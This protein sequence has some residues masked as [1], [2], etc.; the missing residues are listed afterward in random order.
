MH[1]TISD[2]GFGFDVDNTIGATPQ[3]N[4][5]WMNECRIVELKRSQRCPCC[6]KQ[7][8]DFLD[9]RIRTTS[10]VL[11]G[12]NAVQLDSP[13]AASDSLKAIATKVEHLGRV[14]QNAYFVKLTLAEFVITIFRGGR[15][16]VEGT[17]S[18]MEARSIVARVFGG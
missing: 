13:Q 10:A 18:E 15:T 5:P 17:T 11:C 12:K 6:S 3:P 7:Q 4:M 8:F 1:Q 2:K 14:K 16:I 9:G